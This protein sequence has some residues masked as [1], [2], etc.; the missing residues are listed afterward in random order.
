M[1]LSSI[2]SFCDWL[3]S[4]SIMPED[5]SMLKHLSEFPSFL[6]LNNAPSCVY[7]TFCLS[8]HPSV[9]TWVAST[10][11]C[12]EGCCYERG[13]TRTS[14]RPCFW[15]LCT[16]P[17]KQ[18]CHIIDQF[19]AL[20]FEELPYY[21]PQQL[22]FYI[23]TNSQ[24][25]FKVD[26]ALEASQVHFRTQP[27]STLPSISSILEIRGLKRI[28]FLDDIGGRSFQGRLTKVRE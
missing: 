9:D 12:C 17:Q 20:V 7:N 6:R 14:L 21:F 1:E 15:F 18:N 19:H 8:T 28:F 4:L 26:S 5:S 11:A 24:S 27:Q 23:S 25:S 16:Y 2:L 13:Y 3:I 10:F 22:H